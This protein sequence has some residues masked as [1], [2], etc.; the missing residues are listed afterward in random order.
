MSAS[1]GSIGFHGG[2]ASIQR[3][4]RAFP[5]RFLLYEPFLWLRAA[6]LKLHQMTY[7]VRIKGE[8]DKGV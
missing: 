2:D 8:S 4:Y 5:G 6:L 1:Q 3:R 7:L